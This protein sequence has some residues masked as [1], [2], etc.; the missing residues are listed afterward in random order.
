MSHSVFE[1]S[2][3]T[4]QGHWTVESHGMAP[5]P[6]D[7][8]YGASWRNFTVWFAP[9]MELSAVFTGTLA[10]TLGLGFWPGLAAIVIGVILGA[11]PVAY[12]TLWGP[13][14]GMGQLPL[15][16]LPFG[17]TI[18]IPAAVQWLSSVAWDGLVGLFGAEA[19]Q[20][21]FHVPFALGVV[22]V[23]ALEGAVGFLGYEFIHQLEKW[24]SAILAV[25][26]I[27]L[28]WKIVEKVNLPMRSTVHGGTAVGMF[29]LM[30]TIAFG[31]SI[32]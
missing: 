1:G 11:L 18:S 22:I 21:L 6:E 4:H 30:T 24:G 12:L 23:L 31:A 28:S 3:P 8:R 19:A 27:V 29:V 9:N 26:F 2:R 15:A 13:T 17:K 14:T 25:L 5:I 20:I 32:S 7:A 16:R 10:V